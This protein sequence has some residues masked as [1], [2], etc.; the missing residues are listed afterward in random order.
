MLHGFLLTAGTGLSQKETCGD[1]STDRGTALS[2]VL[3]LKSPLSFPSEGVL[4]GPRTTPYGIG[5][6]PSPQSNLGDE[7]LDGCPNDPIVETKGGGTHEQFN[8]A[9][10]D[11]QGYAELLSPGSLPR[12]KGMRQ[13]ASRF[14]TDHDCNMERKP[15]EDM[16]DTPVDPPVLFHC[17]EC[18]TSF[19]NA[20]TWK[21]HEFGTHGFNPVAWTCMFNDNLILGNQCAFCSQAVESFDHFDQHNILSCRNRSGVHRTFAI[22]DRLKQHVQ[23]IHLPS[24]TQAEKKRFEIPEVWSHA[25]AAH[26]IHPNS[27]WCGFCSTSLDSVTSRMEDVAQ[28]FRDGKIMDDWIRRPRI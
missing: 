15:N 9:P 17:T 11:S 7:D 4:A 14:S 5:A 23:Q 20:W 3:P 27:L 16:S 21:R 2:S 10:C 26:K 24:A 13:H 22:K 28:H 8:T 6:Y 1:L 18:K 25:V 12:R 19:K